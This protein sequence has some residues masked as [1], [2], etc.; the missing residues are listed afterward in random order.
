VALLP[1]PLLQ[2]GPWTLPRL[3][4]PHLAL[5]RAGLVAKAPGVVEQEAG[6]RLTP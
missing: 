6:S 5:G 3:W 1:G 2:A 4:Q